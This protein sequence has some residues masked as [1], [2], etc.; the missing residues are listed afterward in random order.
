MYGKI[1]SADDSLAELTSSFLFALMA[2]A[3]SPKVKE[4][5]FSF[6]EMETKHTNLPQIL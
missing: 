5:G 1:C 6:R 4:I 2:C 3:P